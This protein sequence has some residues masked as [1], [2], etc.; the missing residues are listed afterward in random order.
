MREFEYAIERERNILTLIFSSHV[1]DKIHVM[2]PICCP[3]GQ[4]LLHGYSNNIGY[5]YA[6]YSATYHMNQTHMIK[7]TGPSQIWFL[8]S[9]E[10]LLPNQLHGKSKT[11]LIYNIIYTSC[12]VYTPWKLP[13]PKC[14]VTNMRG[15]D[16]QTVL[17]DDGWK[18][19]C[20]EAVG[21][22]NRKKL[23]D[24]NYRNPSAYFHHT[25]SQSPGKLMS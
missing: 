22:I 7:I 23:K 6:P 16:I 15:S 2:N 13:N 18:S 24:S 25:P 8:I 20:S 21:L 4:N 10:K 14:L 1:T 17:N 5:Y 3:N 11:F 19:Q 12:S 9:P